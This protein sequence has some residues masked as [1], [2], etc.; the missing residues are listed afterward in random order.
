[1][2]HLEQLYPSQEFML[3]QA[4][5]RESGSI[6]TLANSIFSFILSFLPM[7]TVCIED[8]K[9]HHWKNIRH[10]FQVHVEHPMFLLGKVTPKLRKH[11]RSSIVFVGSIW[12]ENRGFL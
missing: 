11:L 2:E 9:I 5:M 1:M 12:G 6:E 4:D 7:G 8:W 10:L 3:I